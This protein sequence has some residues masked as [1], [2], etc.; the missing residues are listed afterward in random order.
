MAPEPHLPY[1][2]YLSQYSSQKKTSASTNT[3]GPWEPVNWKPAYTQMVRMTVDGLSPGRIQRHFRKYG[4][5]YSGRQISR[6]VNSQ[7]GM[8]LASLMSVQQ[9]GGSEALQNALGEFLPEALS[10]ELDIMRHPYEATRHRLVAAQDLMDRGKLPKL[11]RQES[12][13]L[14]PQTINV[15]LSPSQMSSFL[16]PPPVIDAEIVEI[17]SDRSTDD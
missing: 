5:D 4:V 8:E 3:Q 14:P 16:L 17:I 12:T 9:N 1:E 11:S 2:D 7:K 10:V 15:Y 13:A 6:V